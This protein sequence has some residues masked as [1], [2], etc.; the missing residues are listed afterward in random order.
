MSISPVTITKILSKSP[1]VVRKLTPGTK[2]IAKKVEA[3]ISNSANSFTK[4]YEYFKKLTSYKLPDST[5][6]LR[7]LGYSSRKNPSLTEGPTRTLLLN[8]F[9]DAPEAI[10]KLKNILNSSQMD[11]FKEKVGELAWCCVRKKD[12]DLAE[13]A[14]NKSDFLRKQKIQGIIGQGLDSTVFLIEGNKVLKIS[15][16]PNFPHKKDFVSGVDTP[17]LKS[18]IINISSK[19]KA[20]CYIQPLGK[21]YDFNSK[22]MPDEIV[23]KIEN[24]FN[25]RIKQ[26]NKNYKLDDFFSNQIIII[27]KKPRLADPECIDGRHLCTDPA[28]CV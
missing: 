7:P 24:I 28:G 12:L 21:S 2:Y 22:D 15:K 10:K 6:Y 1:E 27:N 20:Y 16:R 17:I 11:E 18:E 26:K 25:R 9:L 5:T 14:I 4:I 23:E 19:R 3:N 8:E 13:K